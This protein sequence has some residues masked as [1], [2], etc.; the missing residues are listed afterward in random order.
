MKLKKKNA[1]LKQCPSQARYALTQLITGRDV[2]FAGSDE[3]HDAFEAAQADLEAK[4]EALDRLSKT[5]TDGMTPSIISALRSQYA[6][7]Y[8]ELLKHTEIVLTDRQIL[9]E[10][11]LAANARHAYV[12]DTTP[13]AM[14]SAKEHLALIGFTPEN[15]EGFSA[16][17]RGAT[18]RFNQILFG[19]PAVREAK[20]E[21]LLRRAKVGKLESDLHKTRQFIGEVQEIAADLLATS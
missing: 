12:A 3:L 16:N 10:Q 4:I 1:E 14:Q 19:V 9:I 7:A 17:P 15:Q 8:F 18:L 21:H 6:E 11:S 5:D 2:E 20:S 13:E